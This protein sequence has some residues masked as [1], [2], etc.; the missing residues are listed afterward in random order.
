MHRANVAVVQ[1]G[2]KEEGVLRT[3]KFRI[4]NIYVIQYIYYLVSRRLSPQVREARA[5][6]FFF[7]E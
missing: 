4:E 1:R 7:Y 3:S 6:V 5:R 2:V